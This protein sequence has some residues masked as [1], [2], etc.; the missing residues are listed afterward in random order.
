[1]RRPSS[2]LEERK[3]GRQKEAVSIGDSIPRQHM[4]NGFIQASQKLWL[5]LYLFCNDERWEWLLIFIYSECSNKIPIVCARS[6]HSKNIVLGVGLLIGLENSLTVV[7]CSS[8]EHQEP[9]AKNPHNFLWNIWCFFFISH[10][11]FKTHHTLTCI[12][13]VKKKIGVKSDSKEHWRKVEGLQQHENLLESR[14]KKNL[15]FCDHVFW[16]FSSPH[17]LT[18]VEY[19]RLSQYWIWH[20]FCK[21][22]HFFP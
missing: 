5:A 6:N 14:E 22:H 1:M 12:D 8:Q 16:R 3:N 17:P 4:S 19:S 20:F 11:S 2:L 18:R 21:Y 7:T 9:A 13:Y 10:P 15:E